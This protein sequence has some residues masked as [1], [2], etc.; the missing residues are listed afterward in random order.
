MREVFKAAKAFQNF[1]RK[2]LLPLRMSYQPCEDG[3]FMIKKILRSLLRFHA[4]NRPQSRLPSRAEWQS[5]FL[6]LPAKLALR[7]DTDSRA[8]MRRAFV[9]RSRKSHFQGL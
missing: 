9:P 4:S 2:I 3:F 7:D 8:M 5:E 1:F 6:F